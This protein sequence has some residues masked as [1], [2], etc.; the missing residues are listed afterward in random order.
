VLQ[1]LTKPLPFTNGS[2]EVK[3]AW[4]EL[5]DPEVAAA[6][7][8]YYVIKARVQNPLN[9]NVCEDRNMA[10]VGFHIVQKTPLRPQ[11]VWS[12]FEHVDNVPDPKEPHAGV[13]FSYNSNMP[14]QTLDP[15]AP[16][17][18]LSNPPI[19]DPSPVQVVRVLPIFTPNTKDTN[20]RYQTALVG[21]VWANYQLVVTQWPTKT[22]DP[23]VTPPDDIPGDPFPAPT[24]SPTSVGNTTMETYF[25]DS[26]S[27]MD[28]HDQA[29]QIKTDFV[30]F[31]NLRAQPP[32][33]ELF[34]R[35]NR[36]FHAKQA[37]RAGF[38]KFLTAPAATVT[39]TGLNPPQWSIPGDS[40]LN[41]NATIGSA[42][43]RMEVQV[44]NGDVVEF[45]VTSGNHHAIFENA[46]SELANGIW[47]VVLGSG[48]LVDLPSG[49]FPH[50]DH[51]DAQNTKS[52]T[53]PLIQIRIKNLA[54][55]KGILFGCNPHSE[56]SDG[57][58]VRMLGVL[59]RK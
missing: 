16:T 7:A 50:Y 45:A 49:Q 43:G 36:A 53:G 13:S 52:G 38:A 24:G 57:H 40:T 20:Q 6:K 35:I 11:W 26:S 55:G 28:C 10:L 29:R 12:S 34:R 5:K 30:W 37:G 14:P 15:A 47:E 18:T 56:S 21:S 25:Q 48:E 33:P 39:V 23:S 51:A 32:D 44:N 17:L 41:R 2:I 1:N 59:I 4:R 54:S 3:A 46:K 8:R 27:C 31:I 9:N 42:T 58:N 22:L 19:A